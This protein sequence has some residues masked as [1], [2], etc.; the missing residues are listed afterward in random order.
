MNFEDI[1]KM[2][3]SEARAPKPLPKGTYATTVA[4]FE[5]GKSSQKQTPFVQFNLRVQGPMDDVDRDELADYGNVVGRT[6][7]ATFY[8]YE[9]LDESTYR[10]KTF[11]DNCKVDNDDD[12]EIGQRI[13]ASVNC[14]VGA[15]LKH[16]AN[17]DGM[18]FAEFVRSVDLA[19]AE[20]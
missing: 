14:Q 15:L 9:P 8:F 7:R 2:K 13:E 16:R 3:S 11:L 12:I 6:I 4:G 17:D 18:V 5:Y 10:V 19:K 20:L 1:L